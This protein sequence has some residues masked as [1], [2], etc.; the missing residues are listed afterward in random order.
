[1]DAA[2]AKGLKEWQEAKVFDAFMMN[3]FPP[4]LSDEKDFNRRANALIKEVGGRFIISTVPVGKEG[5][6]TSATSAWRR[7]SPQRAGIT[8]PAKP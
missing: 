7:N 4:T 6:E 5:W 2:L 3:K 8:T 1:M